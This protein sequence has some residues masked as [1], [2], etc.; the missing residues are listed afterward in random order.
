MK[1]VEVSLS[2][3]SPVGNC[4]SEAAPQEYFTILLPC[5]VTPGFFQLR[6]AQDAPWHSRSTVSLASPATRV[7]KS[8]VRCRGEDVRSFLQRAISH[9]MQ[10]KKHY[11]RFLA[12]SL[13]IK[14]G[15]VESYAKG[16]MGS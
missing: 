9:F 6:Q 5:P 14:L 12:F 10:K 11:S 2:F 15:V 8:N 16:R 7:A 4:Y 13:Q 3:E 1:K